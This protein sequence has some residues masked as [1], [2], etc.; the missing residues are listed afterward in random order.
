MTAR[1]AFAE[2]LHHI[3]RIRSSWRWCAASNRA[4]NRQARAIL[5]AV[6]EFTQGCS[7]P[8]QLLRCSLD[9]LRK[10]RPPQHVVVAAADLRRRAGFA[11]CPYD[12]VAQLRLERAD[13]SLLERMEQG[14]AE[15]FFAAIRAVENKYKVCG[16]PPIYLAMRLLGAHSGRRLAYQQC[17]ADER[18]ASWVS[19][20]GMALV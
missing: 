14:D 6:R 1:S 2:E 19:I 10:R 7:I 18:D 5:C 11:T 20:C 12:Y 4:G 8:T 16:L 13:E 17:P 9:V 3:R 15:G